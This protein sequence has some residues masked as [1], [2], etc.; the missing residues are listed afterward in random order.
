MGSGRKPNSVKSAQL[1]RWLASLDVHLLTG[2]G[3]G[4]MQEVSK[5]FADVSARKGM[6]IGIVPGA[7][8]SVRSRY[9]AIQGYPNPWVE[10][11][12]YTHLPDRGKLGS[13]YTSRNHIN[14]LTSDIVV[15]LSGGAGTASEAE[16]SIR[17]GKPAVAWLENSDEQENF[18]KEIEFADTFSQVR[19]FVTD[20]IEKNLRDTRLTA[21]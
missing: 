17:Y 3:M 10:I 1:G 8:D 4:V 5:A 2:S 20:S 11:P 15:L 21:H 14:I 19:E 16:L 6:V 12:I 18:P 9:T 7:Y 13:G